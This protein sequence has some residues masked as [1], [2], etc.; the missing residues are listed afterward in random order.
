MNRSG[1][2]RRLEALEVRRRSL[3]TGSELH[4]RMPQHPSNLRVWISGLTDADLDELI[5]YMEQLPRGDPS[6]EA[7]RF[8]ETDLTA[9]TDDEL[10]AFTDDLDAYLIDLHE[11]A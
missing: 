4:A 8:A 3:Q 11:S 7:L 5:K 9:L 10:E 2:N 6:P 1:L